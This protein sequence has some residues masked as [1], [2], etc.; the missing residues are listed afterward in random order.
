MAGEAAAAAKVKRLLLTHHAPEND[1]E[2]IE[3]LADEARACF[4]NT[5]AAREG[6]IV[7]LKARRRGA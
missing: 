5:Q 7:E 4:P 1:D 6:M 2:A 3:R